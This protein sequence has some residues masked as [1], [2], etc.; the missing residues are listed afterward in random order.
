MFDALTH[1]R[2]YKTVWRIPDALAEIRS[3]RGTHFDLDLTDV[4]LS[5]VARLQRETGNLDSSLTAK[6]ENSGFVQT[7][8]A[9]AAKLKGIDPAVS[10]FEL[11]R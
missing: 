8:R 9:R 11:W 6:A 3:L 7:R 4:S 10:A 1:G 2:P 5:L